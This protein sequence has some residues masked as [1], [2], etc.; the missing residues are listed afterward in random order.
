MERVY[1]GDCAEM[2]ILF[3]TG[4]FA[5][6]EKSI[7]GGM[8]G[9]VY[10]S[11]LGMQRRGHYVRI[12]AVSY[13]NRQWKYKG[14][15][16]ISVRAQNALSETSV[17]KSLFYI[18]QRE[19]IIQKQ[20]KLLDE[21]KKIDVIQYTGWFGIGLLHYNSIP[22]VMR[23]SSYTKI[24]LV[25][26]YSRKKKW[27]FSVVEYLAAKRMNFVFAPSRLMAAGIEKELSKKV[28]VIETPF[29]SDRIKP[30]TSIYQK[31]LKDKKYILFF[32]RMT[33]DKGIYVISEVIR[34]V[35]RE[36]PNIYFVFAGGA[37]GDIVKT[38]K[39]AA[40][41]YI[42]RVIFLGVLAKSVLEPVIQN[43]EMVLM[44]S[45]ADNFPNGC[46]EA[47]ALGKIVI[48]TNGS[49]LEQFIEDGVNGFLARI[50]D[51][52]SLYRC[53]KRVMMLDDNTK[54]YIA[55]NAKQRIK[56][57]DLETYSLYMENLYGEV[58]G[59][60]ISHPNRRK[61]SRSEVNNEVY[62]DNDCL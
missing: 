2:N 1:I 51:T 19:S 58:I 6:N 60:I 42:H 3:V 4:D 22:A 30:D 26:N 18:L 56:R 34:K 57:L 54:K 38:L 52:D 11:A 9:A 40:G 39:T 62:S 10:K 37:S 49:S 15:E 24:Q 21:Q 25:N 46:A 12:L 8:A 61:K 44:P 32:G 20:I 13:Q 7:L 29:L 5:A 17:V 23:V 35:L 43:A 31:K 50:G 28:G 45:L 14:V 36:N 59:I 47:M 16:V 27:L 53:I 48:G 41:E 33:V 55:E